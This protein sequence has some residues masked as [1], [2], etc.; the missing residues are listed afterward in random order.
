MELAFKMN[1]FAGRRDTLRHSIKAVSEAGFKSIGLVFDKPFM[2]LA[3]MEPHRVEEIKLMLKEANLRVASIS[4]CTASGYDRPDDDFTPPGQRFG[5]AFTSSKQEER[6]LRIGHTKSVINFAV[7]LNCG[8]VDTSTGYQPKDMDHADTWRYTRDCLVEIAK[9]AEVMGVSI[10]MEYEPG[11]FGPGGL[12]V[13]DAHSAMSMISDVG[14][15]ALGVTFDVGHAYVCAEDVPATVRL[16]GERMRVVEFE[17]IATE[18]DPE[19][20]LTKRRHYHLVPGKGEIDFKPILEAMKEVHYTGP[21]IVELYS[22][23]DEEPEKACQET[24][25]YLMDKFGDYFK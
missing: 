12:F 21:V 25:Q 18:I 4:S 14:S 24:Y 7:E 1:A 22:L 9:Y 2:W 17:D 5:P 13:G 8:Q 11:E 19:T 20:G 16:L 10:N 23:W 6:G 3:D 15:P